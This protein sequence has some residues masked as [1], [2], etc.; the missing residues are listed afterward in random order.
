[1]AGT[2]KIQW[3]EPGELTILLDGFRTQTALAEHL[4][5]SRESLQRQLRKHGLTTPARKLDATPVPSPAP[6]KKE[7][8]AGEVNREEILEAELQDLRK[9]VSKERKGD[10]QAEK[11]LNEVR[12]AFRSVPARFTAPKLAGATQ[13]GK[14]KHVQAILLSDLHCG[15]VVEPEAVNGLN[16]FNFDVLKR[17]MDSMLKSMVSFARTRAYPI[18]ELHIWLLGDN[19][20]GNIHE[21]LAQTNEFPVA[22]QCWRVAD[23]LA[24]WIEQLVPYYPKI[25]VT[26]VAG[27]HPR[28]QKPHASKQVHDNF[29]WLAYKIIETR[30]AN[31][32]SVS[33][34]FPRSGFIVV[35]I[36]G[37]NVLLFHGD[38]IRSTMPGVPFGGVMRRWNELNKQYATQ[39]VHLDAGAFGHF[40]QPNVIQ[41]QLF[42]NGSVIGTNEFGLKNFGGGDKPTQLL[43]TFHEDKGRLTDVSYLTPA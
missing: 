1:M 15:E 13:A 38:G 6:K 36:A 20:S 29:D 41:G 23:L 14:K 22:E 9:R 17:R 7:I 35:K 24:G 21:E 37:V 39:G 19:L 43:L 5:V 18:E 2:L 10:V 42:G 34:D 27:N 32:K 31:Y 25:V 26:G 30:L 3:P 12:E 8:P 40:H 33:C 16:D 4:G 28:T 11:L